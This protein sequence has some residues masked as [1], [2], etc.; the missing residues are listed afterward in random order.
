MPMLLVPD[1]LQLTR[2]VE[3]DTGR[4]VSDLRV[5]VRPGRLVLSGR[6]GSYYVKQL[7]QHNLR[8]HLPAGLRLDN[9]IVVERWQSAWA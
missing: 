7:A 8:Q 1:T 4:R 2:L 3:S 5:E 9:A 6:T